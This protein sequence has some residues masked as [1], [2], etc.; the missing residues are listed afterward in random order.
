MKGAA[1]EATSALTDEILTTTAR[2]SQTTNV[3]A[4]S[5]QS[6]PSMM[7]AAVAT[8]LPPS[9][10]WNTGNRWPRNAA[11]ATAASTIG[12][13]SGASTFATK[14]ANQPFA[15]SPISVNAAAA[16]LPVRSTLV[17]PGLPDP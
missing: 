3:A 11:S 10:L 7:P 9:N 17:A 15:P 2:I 16:L 12:S 4:A 14:T 8:P 6:R 5:R 13:M 1:T